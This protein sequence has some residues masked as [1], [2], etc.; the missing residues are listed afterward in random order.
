MKNKAEI[1]IVDLKQNLTLVK[2]ENT[3]LQNDLGQTQKD[4]SAE[5]TKT[6]NLQTQLER[7]RSLVESLDQTKDELLQR[8]QSSMTDK[9]GGESEKAVLV[10]DIQTYKRELLTKDQ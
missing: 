3:R 6:Q 9:R 4:L 8:L 2:D 7:M 10:N 5:Q 1:A